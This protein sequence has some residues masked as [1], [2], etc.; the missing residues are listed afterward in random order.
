M[1]KM[2]H[3]STGLPRLIKIKVLLMLAFAAIVLTATPL[4]ANA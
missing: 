2:L 1:T 3:Q 4:Y